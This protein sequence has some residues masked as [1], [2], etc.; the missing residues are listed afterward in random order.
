LKFYF[1]PVAPNPTRVR[2]Y[3]REK[4]L[5]DSATRPDQIEQVTVSL[6][7]GEHK[8]EQHLARN[9]SATLPVLELDDGT[10]ISESLT[11]MQYVEELYP[12][13]VMI[14]ETTLQRALTLQAERKVEMDVLVRL[15]RLIHATNSP[16]GLPSNP[17]IA[18]SERQRLP[19]GLARTDLML[20]DREFLMGDKPS[21]ADCTL[22]GG[23]FFAEFFSWQ[24]PQEYGNITRWYDAFKL[25]PSAQL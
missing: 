8:S 6:G 7:D 5:I 3:L 9:P 25:R 20:T 23:L 15:V 13:P 18:E 22:F 4:G 11:I 21:I 2:T 14:G 24:L 1:S 12:Q 17:G 10:Y 16:L 19:N